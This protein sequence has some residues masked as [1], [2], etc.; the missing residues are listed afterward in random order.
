MDDFTPFGDQIPAALCRGALSLATASLQM[1]PANA[2]VGYRMWKAGSVTFTLSPYYGQEP[3]LEAGEAL[4]MIALIHVVLDRTGCT[5]VD[6][7][8]LRRGKGSIGWGTLA[9][10][11]SQ[12][13]LCMG[14]VDNETC[15]DY[16]YGDTR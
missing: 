9:Q 4:L 5:V 14:A 11:V 7:D 1:I 6:F 2:V 3:T 10:K 15:S 8:I 13:G 12:P 16:F